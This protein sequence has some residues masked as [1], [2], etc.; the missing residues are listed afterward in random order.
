MAEKLTPF[1]VALLTP[2]GERIA[3]VPRIKSV[4]IFDGNGQD[5]HPEGLFS[6]VLFGDL[7][8]PSRDYT[9]GLIKLNTTIMHPYICR[10]I[11]RLKRFYEDIWRGEAFA[12]WNA[13]TKEFLPADMGEEGADTGYFFFTEHIHELVFKKNDS[14][15]RNMMIEVFNKYRNQLMIENHLVLPPGLREIQIDESG[16]S[17]EDECNEMYRKL[18]RLANSLEN[19]KQNNPMINNIRTSI[20]NIT[21]E[22]YDYFQGVLT[23]KGGFLQSKFSKRNIHLGTRNV[24]TSMTMGAEVLGDERS[25]TVDT[26]H[27]GL[28]Q[29]LKA[30]IPHVIYQMRNDRFYNLSFPSKDGMAY[31][32]HPTSL[33]RV[34]V[35]LDDISSDRWMTIEGNEGT[36]SAFERDNFKERPII[37]KGHYLGLVFEDEDKFQLLADINELPA[38]WD[39]KLVRP[40]TYMEWFYLITK[41][42]LNAK[43][44]EVTR[45]PVIGDGSS[46]ISDIYVKT[47][48]PSSVK[49][50]YVDG[51][52]T[53]NIAPE[54]PDRNHPSYYQTFAPHGSRMPGLDGDYDGDKCSFNVIHSEDA[55]EQINE[56]RTKRSSVIN[57]MGNIVYEVEN[58]I[59]VR[60][61]LG[62]TAPSRGRRSQQ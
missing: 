49:H 24:I 19:S 14:V 37:I 20:Q 10:C 50:E 31:L 40:I 57:A 21:N 29:M 43:K 30:S 44:A 25:P 45:Y 1:N 54:Y 22:I 23:G 35:Q 55:I 59:V 42:I 7:G 6:T 11:K 32:V 38:G 34:N 46:Y 4:E 52:P 58:D 51:Q 36:I 61:S 26:T 47:T 53:D 8:K 28:F 12:K 39:K 27:V 16:R 17:T 9:F 41:D 5:F 3:R 18:L 15:K 56:S 33:M 13:S 60:A 62:L 48:S 2:T